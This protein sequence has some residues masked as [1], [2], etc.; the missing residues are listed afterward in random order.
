M[1]VV[2]VQNKVGWITLNRPKVLNS[3]NGE[4][5]DIIFKALRS[6]QHDESIALVCI[7]GA[8]TKG[9]CAGGDMKSLYD[10]KDSNVEEV[11]L[12]FFSTEYQMDLLLHFYPKPVLVFMDG[13]VMGGGVGISAGCSHRIVTER[14]KWAMPEMNIG[15]FP[16]VGASYFL[17]KM[18]GHTGRY[19]AL[20]SKIIKAED[21]IYA[22]LADSYVHSS[23]WSALEAEI[24]SHDWNTSVADQELSELI[25]KYQVE[26]TPKDAHTYEVQEKINHHF[27]YQ[28]M[29]EII[30]SLRSSDGEWEEETR[31][32]LLEKSPI[33]LK[34]TLKQLQLGKEKSLVDCYKMEMALSM[35]FMRNEDFYE[36]VR[37]VLVDK[38][39]SP[40]WKFH[41][42]ESVTEKKVLDFFEWN[43]EETL[44]AFDCLQKRLNHV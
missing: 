15:F 25:K 17:N 28:T 32:T 9:L 34:V 31:K 7:K 42:L 35:N 23:D 38:D 6:F 5:V 11:A 22:G 13:I 3:L 16:D 21:V 19:L 8:G 18:P 40:K 26:V 24:L 4:M 41:T 14:T 36:G 29:E 2:E 33:S 1:V 43:N 20:T 12:R 27:G 37:A 30:D 44:S 10:L 39:R